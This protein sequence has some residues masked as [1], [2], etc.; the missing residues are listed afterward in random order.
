MDPPNGLSFRESQLAAL[1][2]QALTNKEIAYRL[3]LSEGTIK[4]YMS[5][6][7]A[8][9]GVTNRTE[10]CIW[11]LKKQLPARVPAEPPDSEHGPGTDHEGSD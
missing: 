10:L 8:K 9:L 6:I 1:V 7:F 2:S 5:R 3:H 4:E 11:A